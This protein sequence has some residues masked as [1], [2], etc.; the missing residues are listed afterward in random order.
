[1]W[2]YIFISILAVNRR[3]SYA[4]AMNMDN[5]DTGITW[6]KKTKKNKENETLFRYYIRHI[7]MEVSKHC[8]VTHSM[9]CSLT[10][11]CRLLS[12][13]IKDSGIK[14]MFKILLVIGHASIPRHRPKTSGRN[15][16]PVASNLTSGIHCV[17]VFHLIVLEFKLSLLRHSIIRQLKLKNKHIQYENKCICWLAIL[18]W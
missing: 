11:L 10:L 1:M 2:V 18:S 12:I 7:K 3:I 4:V 14:C 6:K 9:L 8:V 15:I 5:T 16:W 13:E 17:F